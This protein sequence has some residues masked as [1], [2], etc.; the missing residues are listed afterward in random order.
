MTMGYDGE[1]L[2]EEP[3]RALPRVAVFVT[4]ERERDTQL[5]LRLHGDAGAHLP[6]ADVHLY[7]APVDAAMRL[8][9][10][11]TP[12]TDI[13]LVRRIALVKERLPH[14]TRIMLRPVFLRTGPSFEATLMRFTMERGLR[15]RMMESQGEF[16]RISYEEYAHRDPE[17]AIATWRAGW[18]TADALAA[19]IEH[20]LFLFSAGS[21]GARDDGAHAS[22]LTW[23]SLTRLPALSGIHA[24]WL[25]RVRPLLAR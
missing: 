7:E 18:V 25:E 20:H 19:Q 11:L 17:L 15:V 9:K 5:L 8:A 24:Q 6:D 1:N 4:H 12:A 14:D 10:T 16:V 13:R 3:Q 22:R 23:A 2:A 21:A